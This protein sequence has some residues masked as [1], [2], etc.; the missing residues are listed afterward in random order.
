MVWGQEGQWASGSRR[1][2]LQFL[3]VTTLITHHTINV[4]GV[5]LSFLP[6]F[7]FFFFVYLISLLSRRIGNSSKSCNK[8]GKFC[9]VEIDAILRI[10]SISLFI[11]ATAKLMTTYPNMTQGH[12]PQD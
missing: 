5:L 11:F 3:A 1:S 10:H 7:P 12:E 6:F 8:G 2:S 9:V 4:S